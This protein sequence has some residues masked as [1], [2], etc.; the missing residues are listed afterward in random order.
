MMIFI[1]S[2]LLLKIN[3]FGKKTFN[4][5]AD[6]PSFQLPYIIFPYFLNQANQLQIFNEF[7][8][9]IKN[10]TEVATASIDCLSS[11]TA[12]SKLMLQPGFVHIS[13]PPHM[14]NINIKKLDKPIDSLE[15]LNQVYEKIV[16][17]NVQTF[18]KGVIDNIYEKMDANCSEKIYPAFV[19]ASK[20]QNLDDLNE[21]LSAFKQIALEYIQTDILFA[22]VDEPSIY[23]A[24]KIAPKTELIY[25]SPSHKN[26]IF[27]P[28]TTDQFQFDVEDNKLSSYFSTSNVDFTIDDLRH[29]VEIHRTPFFADPYQYHLDSSSTFFLAVVNGDKI[30]KKKEIISK[31]KEYHHRFPVVFIDNSKNPFLS[32]SVCRNFNKILRT[33]S[34]YSSDSC[35]ALVN[36][37]E[38]RS[39]VLNQ[40]L[41]ENFSLSLNEII[42]TMDNFNIL[43]NESTSFSQKMFQK[44]ML[45]LQFNQHTLIAFA[46]TL[47]SGMIVLSGMFLSFKNERN[48]KTTKEFKNFPQMQRVNNIKKDD[49]KDKKE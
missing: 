11:R 7:Q 44:L 13:Y 25:I 37:K 4:S 47:L 22:Y 17:G 43:Y 30:L 9:S 18:H 6:P 41:N 40:T 23:D 3:D 38:A 26:T 36:F 42:E 19:L 5:T 28:G 21:K 49:E 34:D 16:N 45:Q 2:S 31:L 33:T 39:I 27:N 10:D 46:S 8:D 29:F 14:P 12:C 24:F 48:K 35:L 32:S 1:L 15:S 20:N